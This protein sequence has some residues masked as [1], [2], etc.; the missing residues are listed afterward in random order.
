MDPKS[1]IRFVILSCFLAGI[2]L[3]I[4]GFAYPTSQSVTVEHVDT[5]DN[6]YI[7]DYNETEGV[8]IVYDNIENVTSDQI[9]A[10]YDRSEFSNTT[11]G[12]MKDIV[13]TNESF[14]IEKDEFNVTETGE[15]FILDIDDPGN[16]VYATETGDDGSLLLSAVGAS[17]IVASI[18]LVARE[19]SRER[20]SNEVEPA[21]DEE[22][23]YT[24]K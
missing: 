13:N 20:K 16:Q 15:R 1:T 12:N 14:S 8:K 22:W 24:V 2:T 11:I 5:F 17:I 21:D 19:F 7:T 23:K 3:L 18:M 10:T 6:E 4:L 9:H